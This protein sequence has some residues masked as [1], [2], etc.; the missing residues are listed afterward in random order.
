MKRLIQLSFLFAL[1]SCEQQSQDHPIL[2]YYPPDPLFRG[3]FVNK[4]YQ[5]NYPKNPDATARSM[6]R[7]TKYLKLDNNRFKTELYNAG[8]EWTGENFYRIEGDSILMEEGRAIDNSGRDTT[9]VDLINNLFKVWSNTQEQPYQLKFKSGES[10]Y[11]YSEYQ[12]TVYDSVIME[13]LAKIFL[14]EWDYKEVGSDSILVKG[15]SKDFF[16]AGLGFWKSED[17][18]S[19]FKSITE[20]VEQMSVEEFEKRANH[21]KHR[22]AFIDPESTLDEKPFETCENIHFIADYYNSDPDGRYLYG[23]KA[24]KDTIFSNLD[25]SKLFDQSGML[26]YRFVVNCQGKAGRFVAEG[27]DYA[28]RPKEFNKETIS[29]LHS[30]LRKLEEWRPVV[31]QNE[32]RDAYFYITFKLENGEIIDILP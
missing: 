4:Y 3:G 2:K 21:G 12:K 5:H 6:I 22:V 10:S 28:Y 29:H 19:E 30:I 25:K 26:T 16:V 20:L 11:I 13:G 15:L 9:S 17:E 7:Y 24:M 23:K 14:S 1:L 8:F 27:Y 31:S 32:S 18:R